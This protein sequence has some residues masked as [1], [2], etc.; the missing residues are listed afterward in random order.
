[1][2]DFDARRA[3][4]DLVTAFVNNHKLSAAELPILL[5]DVFRAISGFDTQPLEST[6]SNET[7]SES[8]S[9]PASA[10]EKPAEIEAPGPSPTAKMP[11]ASA[12]A[13]SIED[14][15][16][17]PNVI[18][19]LITGEKFKILKRHLGK[20]GLTEAEYRQR[21]NLPDDYPMVAPAYAK[22]RRELAT[23]MHASAKNEGA[24]SQPA[25]DLSSE[26]VERAPEPAKKKAVSAKKASRKKSVS[27]RMKTGAD[28]AD[29]VEAVGRD[30]SVETA[31]T[32]GVAGDANAASPMDT[33]TIKA[34]PTPMSLPESAP[35]PDLGMADSATNKPAAKKPPRKR[36]MARPPATEKSSIDA[37][38][39]PASVEVSKAAAAAPAAAKPAA[40]KPRKAKVGI[41]SPENG[42]KAKPVRK[43]RKRLSPVFS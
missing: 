29:P 23:K 10:K 17:D 9:V 37:A 43:E 42:A 40:R 6:R 26:A 32:I 38:A 7:V 1:M 30:A 19:S 22:L 27:S 31:A 33:D 18:V 2:D 39:K 20:H 36:R 12:M 11:A 35:E 15:L 4:L 34:N 13:V 14:S 24:K 3:S 16:A 41:S 5:A 28:V 21:F 25:E 8:D